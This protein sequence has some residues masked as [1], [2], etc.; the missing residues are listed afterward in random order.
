[1]DESKLNPEPKRILSI[2][3][4]RGLTLL[5]LIT[6]IARIFDEM[7]KAGK[8]GSLIAAIQRQSGHGEWY[9][10]YFWDLIQ[11]FFMFIVGVAMPFSV[12]KRL[13]RG[14][15]W[16]QL[17]RH[18]LIRSFWL[19]VLGFML[20]AH[21]KAFYLTNILP[22]LA[23]TYPIAF[24]L[25]RKKIKWQIVVSFAVIIFSDLIYRYWPVEGFNQLLPDNNF[26]NWFDLNTVGHLNPYHWVTFN[27]VSTL[28]HVIWGVIVGKMLM[29]NWSHKKK[30]LSMIIPGAVLVVIGYSL[31]PYI[32]IIERISTATYVLVS[33][34]FALIA[35]AL[36]YA[37]IDI[38]KLKKLPHFFAIFGMNPIFLYLF[39]ELGGGRIF[40]KMVTPFTSRLFSW[41]GDVGISMIN[42]VLVAAMFWYLAYFLYKKKI[43]F[44]L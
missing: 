31:R 15:S 32:P 21:E 1:M 28:A 24:L 39:S 26:G 16:K 30:F 14:E 3:F 29:N 41:T 22:Q 20:G 43:F 9:Q 7:V 8:G 5:I 37:L 17:F 34:G 44:K 42:V 19:L 35:M 6:G 10:L 2:D 27:A 40:Y 36:S 25:I 12:S 38:L 4:F 18:A 23:F 13:A 11:P 33:G